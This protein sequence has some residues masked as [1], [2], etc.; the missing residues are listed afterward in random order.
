[1]Q[2]AKPPGKA[3]AAWLR[4]CSD[5]HPTDRLMLLSGNRE[6]LQSSDLC[7]I[8]G[9]LPFFGTQVLSVARAERKLILALRDHDPL[10]AASN[11]RAI[12]D[13]RRTL[14]VRLGTHVLS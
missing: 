8:R 5:P 13:H 3:L 10:F 14:V 1:M 12:T 4:N 9:H 2:I 6:D 7:P 11:S